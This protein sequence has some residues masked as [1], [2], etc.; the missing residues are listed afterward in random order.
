MTEVTTESPW[1][2]WPL[3]WRIPLLLLWVLI[4]PLALLSFLPGVRHIPVGNMKLHMFMHRI[5][6]RG[7]I[8]VCG[9]R[10]KVI[11]D[12]P[13]PPCLVVANHIT[14]FDIPVLHALWP[15]GLVAKVE[16]RS[17]PL[18]GRLAEIAGSI[19][20]QRG[21]QASR[22]KVNR[23]M[24]ARLRRGEII[25]VFPEGGIHQQRGIKRFHARLFGSAIR[26]GSPIVPMAIRYWCGGDQ[27]DLVVLGAEDSIF[28]SGFRLLAQPNLEVQVRIGQPIR[29]LHIGRD[30]LALRAQQTVTEFYEA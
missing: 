14:W 5:W 4:L 8:A 28:S 9:V 23:R 13:P 26:A 7:L 10:L 2:G 15:M 25:G 12:L 19:F 18:L 27:H 20:I 29:D 11:G 16:I 3:L 21:N 6:M 17:W 22:Q 1:Y 30:A 24:A